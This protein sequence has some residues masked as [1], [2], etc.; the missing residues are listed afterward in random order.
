MSKALI[1]CATRC[2]RCIAA[3]GHVPP[4]VIQG[5]EMA[6]FG[7]VM[8]FPEQNVS[9]ATMLPK[10]DQFET[11]QVCLWGLC[12]KCCALNAPVGDEAR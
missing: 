4:A 9:V 6:R 5:V 1:F 8:L 7:K 3:T 11:F 2:W 12:L 10:V